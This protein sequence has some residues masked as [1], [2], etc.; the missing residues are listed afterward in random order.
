DSQSPLSLPAPTWRP[1]YASKASGG[2]G[3]KSCSRP[4][5][6]VLSDINPSYDF[7]L[8]GSVW[9]DIGSAGDPAT[10]TSLNV[11]TETNAIGVAEGLV[12]GSYFIGESNSVKDGAP[13]AKE[14]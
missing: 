13:T 1:P 2:G 10:M 14:I 6:T 5:M 9:Q 3:F 11:S 8:P 7:K 4:V 12:G